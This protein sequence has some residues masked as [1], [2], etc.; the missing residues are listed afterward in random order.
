MIEIPEKERRSWSP[1]WCRYFPYDP[2]VGGCK[3]LD[4]NCKRDSKPCDALPYKIV[5]VKEEK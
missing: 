5:P 4:G 2:L 1:W 3:S